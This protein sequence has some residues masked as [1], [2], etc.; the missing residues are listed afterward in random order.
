MTRTLFG[1]KALYA[2]ISPELGMMFFKLGKSGALFPRVSLCHND[3][4][5]MINHLSALLFE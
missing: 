4:I 2:Q 1:A 5:V 3:S